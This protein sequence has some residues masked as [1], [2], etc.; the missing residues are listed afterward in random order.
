VQVRNDYV[1]VSRGMPVIRD[2]IAVIAIFE[3]IDVAGSLNF[4]VFDIIRALNE[5][6]LCVH[7][8]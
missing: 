3:G 7:R 1:A 8:Q 6:V 2:D 4:P 5:A